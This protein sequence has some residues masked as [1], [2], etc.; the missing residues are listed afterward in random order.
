MASTATQ[1]AVRSVGAVTPL[2]DPLRVVLTCPYS[3]SV[4][5]GVQG[6]V[7]GL[8]RELRA[9]GVDARVLAPSDGPPPE[10]GVV[11]LGPTR[12]FSSNGSI[13]PITVG[14]VVAAR[15][16]EAVRALRPDVVHLHEPL[17][18]M[19]YPLILGTDLPA[20]G[21][22]HAAH[23]GRNAWYDTFRYPLAKMVDR[24][25][26]ITAVSEEARRNVEE[27]TG[28]GCEIIPNGV[29]VQIFSQSP[30]WPSSQPAIAFL[31]RHEPRKGLAVLL[32]AFVGID[33]AVDLWIMGE[34]PQ[35]SSLRSQYEK[36]STPKK[37]IE[38][39]GHVSESEK[40]ARLGGSTIAC[41]PSLEGESFGIV[42]LEAMAARTAVVASDLTG[43]RHVAR[44]NRE[45]IMV[46]PGDV[47][48][49][50]SALQ[51]LLDKKELRQTMV[52]AGVRR[53][54]KFLLENVAA[55]F[56]ELYRAA[57]AGRQTLPQS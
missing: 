20:I 5:G 53:T 30:P 8:A 57:V 43:Y 54:E 51:E 49:L 37:R 56:H 7:L 22:F 28:G 19:H 9:Q 12:R 41:F 34:G 27:L 1:L 55:K 29:D 23:T 17:S 52:D 14:R 46:H 3:L 38:W 48:G 50:R 24:L 11:S 4:D 47:M 45:G 39:I 10:P 42:L 35:T 15:T 2:G 44:P 13:A 25:S 31:G 32:E 6:Q 36:Y 26:A 33:R 40:A 16:F 21:T 18:P